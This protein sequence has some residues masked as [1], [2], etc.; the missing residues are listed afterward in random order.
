MLLGREIPRRN[1]DIAPGLSK[2]SDSQ[3]QSSAAAERTVK[4]WDRADAP[5]HT[6]GTDIAPQSIRFLSGKLGKLTHL[7]GVY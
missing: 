7:T 5:R 1:S 2:G 3:K 4:R 6:T